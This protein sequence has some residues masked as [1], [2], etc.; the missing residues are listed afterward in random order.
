MIHCTLPV[1]VFDL[2]VLPP[3]DLIAPSAEASEIAHKKKQNIQQWGFTQQSTNLPACSYSYLS[4]IQSICQKPKFSDQCRLN[5]PRFKIRKVFFIKIQ[6]H[7]IFRLSLERIS[8]SGSRS[9][10]RIFLKRGSSRPRDL[11]GVQN[12]KWGFRINGGLGALNYGIAQ[13]NT[14]GR[15]NYGV[16]GVQTDGIRNKRGVVIMPLAE[17]FGTPST[18]TCLVL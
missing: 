15:S 8:K 16:G 9:P 18:R 14:Q 5:I 7:C 1:Q 11:N 3:P 4:S 12:A 6:G 13:E 10:D 17:L 2:S